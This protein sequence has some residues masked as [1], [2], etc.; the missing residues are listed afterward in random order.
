M[1]LNP[2]QLLRL[3]PRSA[4]ACFSAWQ[5][6][7]RNRTGLAGEKGTHPRQTIYFRFRLL[8]TSY[9]VP[10]FLHLFYGLS[11]RKFF[12]QVA[13]LSFT[14][15]CGLLARFQCPA[16]RLNFFSRCGNCRANQDWLD[17]RTMQKLVFVDDSGHVK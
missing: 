16:L 11:D 17:T 13:F 7:W 15:T 4:L 5:P 12:I 3:P 6:L 8:H 2:Q 14:E 9:F 10:P 1:R